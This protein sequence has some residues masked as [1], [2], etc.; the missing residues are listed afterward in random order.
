M[1]LSVYD[2]Q[3]IAV[4]YVADRM[5]PVNYW[6]T[7]GGSGPAPSIPTVETWSL[8]LTPATIIGA[9]LVEDGMFG[10]YLAGEEWPL[11]VSALPDAPDNAGCVFDGQAMVE[12][13]IHRSSRRRVYSVQLL[14]RATDVLEGRQRCN[15]VYDDLLTFQN[16]D[17]QINSNYYRIQQ[18][19][20]A[21]GIIHLGIIPDDYKRRHLFSMNM[22]SVV[23][24]L[25][26][27]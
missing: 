18:I 1:A 26:D 2:N 8:D 13:S 7:L 24:G 15:D 25:V 19:H 20:F 6:P 27:A 23:L 21:T 22:R 12:R 3:Y 17:L 10:A 9:A 14:V 16:R 11:F 5:W 4:N